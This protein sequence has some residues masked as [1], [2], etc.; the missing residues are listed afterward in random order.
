MKV[1]LAISNALVIALTVIFLVIYRGHGDWGAGDALN[2]LMF[3]PPF[4]AALTALRDRSSLRTK[5]LAA[6]CSAAWAVPL[7]M[8]GVG[9]ST[10]IGGF[11][12]LLIVIVPALLLL[13][14]N[15]LWFVLRIRGG[16]PLEV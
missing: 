16:A 5:S 12:A 2:V 9:A 4:L 15:L 7:A 8:L 1:A 11:V 6:W 14:L 10:G 3:R 13:L